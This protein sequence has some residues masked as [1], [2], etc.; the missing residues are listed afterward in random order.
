MQREREK[1][2]KADEKRMRRLARKSM[3]SLD[4]GMDESPEE[5]DQVDDDQDTKQDADQEA[6]GSGAVD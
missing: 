6:T 4:P 5:L 3:D 1:K 2:R